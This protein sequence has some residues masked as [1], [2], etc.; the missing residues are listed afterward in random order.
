MP[1]PSANP[2]YSLLEEIYKLLEQLK[3]SMSGLTQA[4]RRGNVK[5][6]LETL[7]R[8]LAEYDITF[9]VCRCAISYAR[10]SHQTVRST[11]CFI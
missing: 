1:W 4:F 3:S 5:D 7:Q 10:Q 6:E 9:L 8:R 2:W 11:R